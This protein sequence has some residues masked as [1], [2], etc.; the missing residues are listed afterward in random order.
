MSTLEAKN[1]ALTKLRL[2]LDET[3]KKNTE[4]QSEYE[5]LFEEVFIFQR[6]D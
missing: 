4:L 3:D 6:H 5:R 1:A 2:R